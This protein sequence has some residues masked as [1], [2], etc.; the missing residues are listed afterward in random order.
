LNTWLNVAW[1]YHEGD[2]TQWRG[3]E[4]QRRAT[5]S[6]MGMALLHD[7]PM[8]MADLHPEERSAVLDTLDRFGVERADFRGYWRPEAIA[9]TS[10]PEAAISAYVLDRGAR[11]LL[12]VANLDERPKPVE[13]QLRRDQMGTNAA[14][15]WTASS[16]ATDDRQEIG[17]SGRFQWRVPGH[18]FDLIELSPRSSGDHHID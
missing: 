10:T 11:A 7:I 5:R 6:F 9:E 13:I 4:S 14:I 15:D 8:W 17:S 16:A 2:R 3:S 1:S 18:D 12:V